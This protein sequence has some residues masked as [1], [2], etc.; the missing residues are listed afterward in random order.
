AVVN[1]AHFAPFAPALDATSV[2]VYLNGTEAITDFVYG[3]IVP[4]VE[5]LVGEY[6]VEIVPT[7]TTTP[8]I[9]GTFMLDDMQY[10][11]SAIGDGVNQP[12]ELFALVDETEMAMASS[13]NADMAK[14]RIAHLAPWASGEALVDICT[15]SGTAILNNVGYKDF[16]DPYLEL[17]SG[18]YDLLIAVAG[19]D[20]GTVALDIPAIF[21]RDGTITDVFAIGGANEYPLEVTSITGI[22]LIRYTVL[23]FV[24]K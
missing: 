16:T 14:L 10:T 20:C 1:V 6:L 8:A 24:M 13:P 22:T 5:L 2:S 19:T 21:L 3:E 17:E 7:G 18:K 12:L 15:D 11:L 4:G 23:P 9:T